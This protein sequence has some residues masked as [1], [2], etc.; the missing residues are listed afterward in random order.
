M[1]HVHFRPFPSDSLALHLA[2]KSANSEIVSL[3]LQANANAKVANS[4]GLTS[5]D[6]AQQNPD[7]YQMLV[8]HIF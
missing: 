5:L 2:V 7:I 3:L 4:D 1:I 6:L 8:N